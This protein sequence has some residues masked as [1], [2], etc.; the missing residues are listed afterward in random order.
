MSSENILLDAPGYESSEVTLLDKKENVIFGGFDA[1][2][3]QG[4][5][6]LEKKDFIKA[7]EYFEKAR[8]TDITRENEVVDGLA[9]AYFGCKDEIRAM[10]WMG[11][12]SE[13]F[14]KEK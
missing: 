9:K 10:Y 14:G 1:L 4:N 7:A 13:E 3:E 6:C 2:L 5:T 8:K 11:C 12:A